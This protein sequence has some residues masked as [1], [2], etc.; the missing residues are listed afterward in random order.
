MCTVLHSQGRAGHSIHS[1]QDSLVLRHVCVIWVLNYSQ[2]PAQFSGALELPPHLNLLSAISMW[3]FFRVFFFSVHA[4]VCLCVSL[5]ADMGRCACGCWECICTWR[6]KW[7]LDVFL[8]HW[9]CGRVSHWDDK[10]WLVEE[11]ALG[12][13]CLRLLSALVTG[14]HCICLTSVWVLGVGL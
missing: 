12:I 1:Y 6:P 11:L 10:F 5:F 9:L 14:C 2:M 8:H 7:I 13:L 3:K 4:C